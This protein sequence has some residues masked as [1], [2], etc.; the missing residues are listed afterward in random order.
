M[1]KIVLAAA[2]AAIAYARSEA[3][4]NIRVSSDNVTVSGLSA[5][6]FFAVQYHVAFSS[7]I[8]GAGIVAG[9][10]YYCSKGQETEAITVCLNE[11]Q[12]IDVDGLYLATSRFVS[13]GDIDTT[14]NMANDNIYL[15]S[16]TAD[17]V[18]NPGTMHKL[19]TYY[20]HY[21][22]KGQIT[23]EYGIHSAHGMPTLDY[24]RE[25]ASQGSP[26]IQKCNYDGAGKILQSLLGNSLRAAVTPVKEN[27]MTFSQETFGA[28]DAKMGDM[29]Y[30]YVPTGC[31]NATSNSTCRLHIVFHGCEQTLGDIGTAYVEHTG[32]NGWAE[33]NNIVML[34]P[35]CKADFLAG[36]PNG[37]WD[38]WGYGSRDFNTQKG[39]Q[40]ALI[41]KIQDQLTGKSS[42]QDVTLSEWQRVNDMPMQN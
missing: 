18:V 30:I 28:T 26:F 23:T 40:M 36:N 32:Y 9:G 27:V 16:G 39:P 41:K 1:M 34:Y 22:T 21:V 15:Y 38:W 31:K 5:G 19:E 37:C 24:G 2:F 42:R 20:R 10:P 17:H 8:S 35:Q 14:D 25:C 6:G 13:Q 4:P 12:L 7:S 3:L 11:P 29:G 33:A